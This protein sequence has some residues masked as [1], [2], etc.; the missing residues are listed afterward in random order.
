MSLFSRTDQE[1][2]EHAH[3]VEKNALGELSG[4][5]LPFKKADKKEFDRKTIS[6]HLDSYK[7]LPV[8]LLEEASLILQ[9]SNRALL[10]VKKR[11]DVSDLLT[12]YIYSIVL[13]W[14]NKY[15]KEEN[16]LPE[17]NERRNALIASIEA[18]HQLSTSYKLLFR[19]YYS[20]KKKVFNKDGKTAYLFA[21]RSL[22]LI[23][24]EQR[25]RAL[26]YQKL[27]KVSWQH[28]NQIFFSFAQHNMVNESYD[29]IGLIGVRKSSD[30]LRQGGVPTSS[31]MKLYISIQLF[32]LLDVTTWP[33][34]MFHI[35]DAYLDMLK[36]E[37]L[38]VVAD[39]GKV[40]KSG[41]IITHFKNETSPSFKRNPNA[42]TPLLQ[43][44]YSALYNTLVKDHKEIAKQQFLDVFDN[45]KVSQPLLEIQ[46]KD[47]VPVIELMIM[48]L[49]SR[50]RRQKRHASFD[51]SSLSVYFGFKDVKRLLKDI[52]APDQARVRDSRQFVDT[53]AMSS[54]MLAEEQE[55]H[56][57]T[58]WNISNFS[59][60]GLLIQTEESDFS[61]PIHIDMLVAFTLPDNIKQPI[62][63]FVR[64]LNRPNEKQ[65]EIAVVR[66]SNYAETVG[67]QDQNE[68]DSSVAKAVI[69]IKNVH[70]EWNLV[71]RTSTSYK[72][73]QPLKLVRANGSSLPVRLGEVVYTKKGFKVFELRSPGL[74]AN[75]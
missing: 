12:S 71:I 58:A 3:A 38:K 28:C 43:L 53:L 14:Y 55:S 20:D 27:P 57:S 40:L 21:A 56:M 24:L 18:I 63:G 16:S 46:V 26:R 45:T 13:L 70:S 67:I 29:V 41:F 75:N 22:E 60:G 31:V 69:L 37:G 48:G 65:V 5:S 10:P 33:T 51:S 4:L 9:K 68:L 44:N 64:R 11:K 72:K 42:P 73:G 50:E 1:K 23:R 66:L 8:R 19:D 6:L 30:E 34:R 7:K 17:S 32:G 2:R 54:A 52:V 62:L 47:R 59:A 15:Q 39:D 74:E 49:T 61:N 25:L 35:P 36:G